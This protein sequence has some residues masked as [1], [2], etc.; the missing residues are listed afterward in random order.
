L[1]RQKYVR[2]LPLRAFQ[3]VPVEFGVIVIQAAI[4]GFEM[5]YLMPETP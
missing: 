3:K 2:I 5:D 4:P 1:H